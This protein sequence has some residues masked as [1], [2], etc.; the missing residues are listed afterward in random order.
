MDFE[1]YYTLFVTHYHKL[2]GTL[3]STM[4]VLR[5]TIK[6]QNVGDDPILRN[7]QPLPQNSW[8]NPPPQQPMKLPSPV[9]TGNPT[10]GATLVF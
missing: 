2:S 8:N 5:Q 9:K 10:P 6:V 3:T 7:L 1:P 4:T